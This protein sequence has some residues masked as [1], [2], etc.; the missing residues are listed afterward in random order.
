MQATHALEYF[1]L[2][3]HRFAQSTPPTEKPCPAL[4]L[5]LSPACIAGTQIANLIGGITLFGDGRF[6]FHLIRVKPAISL[7]EEGM[8][9]SLILSVF[10]MMTVAGCAQS[11]DTPQVVNGSSG[12][13]L[14]RPTS[15]SQAAVEAS[16]DVTPSQYHR[17]GARD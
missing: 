2:K 9:S 7:P 3:V 12:T 8:K 14:Q 5:P 6:P 10:A 11:T 1:I 15:D 17:P 16:T 4:E 13:R